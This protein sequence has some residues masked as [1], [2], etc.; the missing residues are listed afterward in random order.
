MVQPRELSR[1][2]NPARI[3]RPRPSIFC[4]AKG[5]DLSN[6]EATDSAAAR[7]NSR[8]ARELGICLSRSL[9]SEDAGGAASGA[10]SGEVGK[11]ANVSVSKLWT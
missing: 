11:V 10:L 6:R 5:C 1:M 2:P 9:P 4:R 8:S 3:D 7:I